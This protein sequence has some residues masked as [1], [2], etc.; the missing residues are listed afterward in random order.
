MNSNYF[1]NMCIISPKKFLL[2]KHWN[3][4]VER[5]KEVENHIFSINKT[6]N[7]FT[8]MDTHIHNQKKSIQ[9]NLL[10]CNDI[11]VKI[12]KEQKR[13]FVTLMQDIIFS[14]VRILVFVPLLLVFCI[15]VQVFLTDLP[16]YFSRYIY[17]TFK[18][19]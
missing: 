10:R 4:E 13:K 19:I 3:V 1:R 11:R 2:I 5:Y 9:L 15:L 18:H 14:L 6:S 16:K 12:S 7:I 8:N 17:F